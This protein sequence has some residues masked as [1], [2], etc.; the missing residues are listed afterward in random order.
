MVFVSHANPEDNRFAS[1]LSL[2]LAKH[3]YPVWCDLTKLL[4]GEVFW[5]DIEPAI[6]ERTSKFLYVLSRTSNEKQGSRDEL[7]LALKVQ[8]AGKLDDFVIP[9]WIDDLPSSEFNVQIGRINSIRFQGGWADGL[10][11]LLNK[12]EN[13]GVPKKPGFS[14]YAVAKWWRERATA[15]FG[16]RAEPE[17]LVTNW[18]PIRPARLFFHKLR[19]ELQNAPIEPAQ[20]VPYPADRFQDYI[21][22]FSPAQ[23]FEGKLGSGVAIAETTSRALNPATPEKLPRLWS[24]AD[25][26][27]TVTKLLNQ[28]WQVMLRDR[29]LP[30]HAFANGAVAFY[31]RQGEVPNDEVRLTLPSGIPTHRAVVGYKTMPSYVR[32]WHLAVEAK[33]ITTPVFGFMIKLHVLFSSDGST[34]W[35]GKDRL[36]RAR[37]SQCKDWWNDRWLD[38]TLAGA[39]FLAA[40]GESIRLQVGSES[41]LEVDARPLLLTSPIS[42]DE[43]ALDSDPETELGIETAEDDWDVGEEEEEQES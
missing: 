27:A 1:W 20:V 7:D 32:Y 21:V 14:P 31:F 10:T 28:A 24:Y 36:A 19:I 5:D 43:A 22:S 30:L 35:E 2:Q 9:L 16:I 6:R 13:D 41:F 4:G 39:S 40:G 37:R 33:A 23:D 3:G 34:I 17:S 42:Y 12:L 8:R 11:Q 29:K 38:L 25:E 18:A 15:T 26:R